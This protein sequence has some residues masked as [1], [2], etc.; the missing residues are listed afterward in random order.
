MKKKIK[1]LAC[2]FCGW[3]GQFVDDFDLPSIFFFTCKSVFHNM[4]H[5]LVTVKLK[6]TTYLN[7]PSMKSTTNAATQG[8]FPCS[9][10]IQ[11]FIFFHSRTQLSLYYQYWPP[12]SCQTLPRTPQNSE[13]TLFN[14]TYSTAMQR[15]LWKLSSN[16]YRVWNFFFLLNLVYLLPCREFKHQQ[17]P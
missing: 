8:Y 10:K 9:N 1:H 11:F 7:Q 6:D 16:S 17:L 2:S 3:E 5:M 15:L 4:Q 12:K 14:V 13:K